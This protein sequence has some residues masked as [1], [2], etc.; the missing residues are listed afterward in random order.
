MTVA[1][2]VMDVRCLPTKLRL[3]TGRYMLQS[4]CAPQISTTVHGTCSLCHQDIDTR[5][6]FLT[7]CQSLNDTRAKVLKALAEVAL[8]YSIHLDCLDPEELTL[9]MINCKLHILKVIDTPW[10]WDL[11]EL[12]SATHRLCYDLHCARRR[13][14]SFSV[15]AVVSIFIYSRFW[16]HS[17]DRSKLSYNNNIYGNNV[18]LNLCL[19]NWYISY[20][21]K[22]TMIYKYNE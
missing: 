17:Y 11:T 14:L 20:T 6:H 12:E 19:C 18:I 8:Q 3:M 22:V 15:S 1:P 7:S 4:N 16:W 9:L 2:S 21:N 13:Y 5:Q 10:T